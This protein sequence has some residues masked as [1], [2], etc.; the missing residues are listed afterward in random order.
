MTFD[1]RRMSELIEASHDL[2][3]TAMRRIRETID[4]I[5]QVG[6]EVRARGHVEAPVPGRRGVLSRS[7]L[8]AGAIGGK[9]LGALLMPR[10]TAAYA[11]SS[12]DVMMLQTAASIENLAVAV[13]QKAAG[14]PPEVSGASIPAIKD[15]VTIAIQ[16]HTDHGAAFNAGATRL[17]GMAQTGI[18]QTVNDAVVTPALGQI[19]GPSDVVA[20]AQSLEDAA[21]QTYVKYGGA[22]DDKSAVQS[23]ASIAAVEAQHGAVLLAVG[24]LLA[25]GAT[26]LITISPPV[27][28]SKLPAAAGSVGFPT[29][30]YKTEAARPAAEGAVP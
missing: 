18:D 6:L 4:G 3:S 14:L 7:L 27:D 13:Y 10:A 20:L 15:F 25:G 19:K 5:V 22:V 26:E 30:F 24:A 1:Q 11:L 12:A 21:T 17:G 8:A 23:F 29:S 2:H 16:H 9:A 28:V